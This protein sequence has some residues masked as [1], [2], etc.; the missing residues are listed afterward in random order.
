MN[1]QDLSYGGDRV[2]PEW[3]PGDQHQRL[4]ILEQLGVSWMETAVP[5]INCGCRYILLVY[6][7]IQ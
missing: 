4:G 1:S 3:K 2:A 7:D 5:Q 6:T